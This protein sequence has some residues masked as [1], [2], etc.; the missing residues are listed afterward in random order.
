MAGSAIVF[1]KQLTIVLFA[2]STEKHALIIH[3]HHQAEEKLLSKTHGFT[4]NL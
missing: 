3:S 4:N 2:K 1:I